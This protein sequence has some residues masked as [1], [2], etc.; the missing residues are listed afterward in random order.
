MICRAFGFGLLAIAGLQLA[1][2]QECDMEM[3]SGNKVS[4][5]VAAL[6]ELSKRELD[7]EEYSVKLF[8]MPQS[9]IVIFEPNDADAGEMGSGSKLTFEVEISKVDRRVLRANFAR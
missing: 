2:A 4:I 5:I 9:T 1:F 6:P 8:E 7:I 3:I